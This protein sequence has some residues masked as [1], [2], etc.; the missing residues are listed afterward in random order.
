MKILVTGATGFI[1]NHVIEKLLELK[2]HEIIAS[3]LDQESNKKFPW[4]S[5]VTFI[6]CD[7]YEKR[8]NYFAYF[9]NPD[10]LIHLAWEGLPNF[11]ELYHFER[12]LFNDYH[13]LKNMISHG[14][15]RLS[16][17][18]TCFEYG[19]KKGSLSED[20]ETNPIIAYALAKDTL[21]KFIQELAKIYNFKIHWIR[22][23][24]MYGKGQSPKSIIPQLDKALDNSEESFNMSG[25][26]QLRDYLPVEKVAEYIIKISLQDKIIG[27]INC[28]SGK[29]LS[30]K[31]LVEEHIKRRKKSIKLNLGYYPYPDYVSM[32][33]WGDTTKLESVLSMFNN[34][35]NS[36]KGLFID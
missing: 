11:K 27:I 16:V 24:Y 31:K 33:F 36:V 35:K 25:G 7:L 17:T 8:E 18:G 29:P 23:F 22:L 15:K 14:L 5:D 12:N 32:E 13:F 20:M 1:G 30:I 10:L 3:A 6:P 4:Y 2:E 34:K 19:K 26:E 21:R 9:Q 28:C